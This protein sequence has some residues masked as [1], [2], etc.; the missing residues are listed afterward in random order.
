MPLNYWRWHLCFLGWLGTVFQIGAQ[1][2]LPSS[3]FSIT[4]SSYVSSQYASREGNYQQ[5]PQNYLQWRLQSRITLYELP[6]EAQ[7]FLTTI[8]S[9]NRQ[10]PQSFR[11]A[12]DTRSFMRNKL[13]SR[14]KFLS[15]FP[16]LEVGNCHPDYSPLTLN[17][18]DLFGINVEFNP[19]LFYSAF[20][21]GK[22]KQPLQN[23]PALFQVYERAVSYG[24][25]G[26]GKKEKNHL[27]LSLFHARD[28]P[29]S[30]Q[31]EG[32]KYYQDPDTL[33]L[34]IGTF[35][36]GLDSAYQ[37]QQP[38]ENL[39]AESSFQVQMFNKSFQ[40]DGRLAGSLTTD[41][42]DAFPAPM[43]Q[44]PEWVQAGITLNASSR[45]DYAFSLTP[46]FHLHHTRISAG[47]KYIGPGYTTLGIPCLRTNTS[48]YHA[49]VSQDFW[50]KKIRMKAFWRRSTDGGF[51]WN[52]KTTAINQYGLHSGFRLQKWTNINI[53]IIH[54]DANSLLNDRVIEYRAN[55]LSINAQLRHTRRSTHF[56]T[57]ASVTHQMANNSLDAGL[58]EMKHTGLLISEMLQFKKPVSIFASAGLT[59]IQT[60]EKAQ[61][62]LQF[63]GR[64]SYSGLKWMSVQAGIAY[65]IWPD[66]IQTSRY[67]LNTN[68]Q[69]KKY[70]RIQLQAYR[71]DYHNV[72][73]P[74]KNYDDFILRLTLIQNW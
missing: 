60:N 48:K 52:P 30:L 61:E 11:F 55:N 29:A 46:A 5:V 31:P 18:V 6:F 16:S 51:E 13:A 50:K 32:A 64:I 39:V 22:I 71:N 63:N 59:H 3:G 1:T 67:F 56:F 43:E 24:S 20:C 62:V 74:E 8:R 10:S 45:A 57:N 42:L 72:I 34:D 7:V 65:S 19:G 40:L 2:G 69:W 47:M 49:E 53:M 27:M 38:K 21:K 12:L 37:Y 17:G 66:Q 28:D 14:Y 44:I 68:F 73:S 70:G 15:W 58:M 4:G 23:T 9:E 33:V 36:H 54:Y 35:I 41:K 25:I 26:L